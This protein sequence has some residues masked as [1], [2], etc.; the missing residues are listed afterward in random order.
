MRETELQSRALRAAQI[1]KSLGL[2]Q[3]QVAISIG[4]SQSQVSRIL[5][6]HGL[7]SSRL[8][9][10]LCNYAE[11]LSQK[12]PGDAIRSNQELIDALADTWD[13]TPAH[14]KAL[15]AVIRSLAVLGSPQGNIRS[16]AKKVSSS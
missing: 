15:A 5:R 13:G 8:F 11:N 12:T 9:D 10:E 6:G 1:Y 2:T 16:L 4:A 3:E 7:R 14:S